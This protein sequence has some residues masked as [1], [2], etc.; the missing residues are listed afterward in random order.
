MTPVM[1]SLL[2]VASSLSLFSACAQPTGGKASAD[3]LGEAV[4]AGLSAR[5]PA[6]LNGLIATPEQAIAACPR[7]E[8]TRAAFIARRADA[9]AKLGASFASCLQADWKGAAVV[10]VKGGGAK[11]ALEG[12]PDYVE[13][14]DVTI[15]VDVS[16]KQ[17]LVRVEDAVALGERFFLFGGVECAGGQSSHPAI[18]AMLAAVDEVCACKDHACANVAAGK[19]AK[20]LKD[21]E[22]EGVSPA[23][24]K[25][26]G[27]ATARMAEC[28]RE[29]TGAIAPTSTRGRTLVPEPSKIPR[30]S[31][32]R[33]DRPVAPR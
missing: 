14:K 24:A 7:L 29:L 4:V 1:R 5:D 9:E 10:G 2:I 27:K 23:D 33:L 15:T 21:V 30:D 28:R 25:L 19:L 20:S 31:T 22:L 12:C 32:Q 11:K 16:G 8:E 13:Q 17:H 6:G 18:A 26:V 3:E